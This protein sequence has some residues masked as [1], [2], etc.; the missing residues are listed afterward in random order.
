MTQWSF[1]VCRVESV[2]DFFY[3]VEHETMYAS[4]GNKH[5][6]TKAELPQVGILFVTQFPSL[7]IFISKKVGFWKN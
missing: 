4:S 1:D 6:C 2:Q 3:Q 5:F 7:G